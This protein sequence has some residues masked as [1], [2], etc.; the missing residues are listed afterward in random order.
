[1]ARVLDAGS[2]T[3]RSSRS[4]GSGVA[5]GIAALYT[6]YFFSFFH[7][8]VTG[9]LQQELSAIAEEAGWDPRF[10]AVAVS[11]AYFYTYAAMQIPAGI[12]ADALGTRR[13]AALSTALMGLGSVLSALGSPLLII[14]GRLMVGVGAAA[15]WVSMQRLIGVK[16]GKVGGGLLTGLGLMVGGLGNVFATLPAHLLVEALGT[17]GL[18]L[19]AGLATLAAS[20]AIMHLVDDEGLGLGSIREGLIAT[21]RQLRVVSK[22][23]HSLA[24]SAAG[25]GTYAAFLAYMSFWAPLYL[26]GCAGLPR[27]RAAGLLLLTSLSFTLVVPLVGYASDASGRRK[28]VLVV[29]CAL[30]SAAWL[31]A[32]LL[33]C[34]ARWELLPA[35]SV[36]L[37]VVAA[38]HSVISPMARE[39][40]RPEFSGTTLS[41][42]NGITF[43]GVALYQVAT[44][45]LPSP[46]HALL[47]FATI[48]AVAAVLTPLVHE[49]MKEGASSRW[50]T[51]GKTSPL[52][53][54]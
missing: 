38:T 6:A 2:Q 33:A 10:F 14:A 43:A 52:A 40:Y 48:A 35:Y 3:S 16:V 24:L 7:R 13:Y 32:V 17:S 1:V 31:A 20:A 4:A 44:Y 39:F 27:D 34:T 23:S 9:V 12:L 42:V 51:R 19:V 41:F 37:G 15:I 28:P 47:L 18:F 30:H 8:T 26:S 53:A 36:L 5:A 50:S 45:V 49:T 25:L 21:L 22:N 29:S 46:L 11:S 54:R